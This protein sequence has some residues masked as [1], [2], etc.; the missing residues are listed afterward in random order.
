MPSYLRLSVVCN[1]GTNA[2]RGRPRCCGYH[3]PGR[4]ECNRRR[5]HEVKGS[6]HG[7]V[8]RGRSVCGGRPRSH[9]L[10]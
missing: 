3:G 8:G 7:G 1:T 2:G 9:G 6:G 10:V 4:R 5:A